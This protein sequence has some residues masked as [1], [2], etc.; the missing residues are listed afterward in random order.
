MARISHKKH[1]ELIK[2]DDGD[3]E[4]TVYARSNGRDTY[5]VTTK[6]HRS[7]ASHVEM[8]REDAQRH[9]LKP[10]RTCVEAVNDS[11]DGYPTDSRL[12]DTIRAAAAEAEAN[13]DDPTSAA[14]RAAHE[15][16]RSE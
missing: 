6:C 1:R 15:H 16:D 3:P 8:T 13:G 4:T 9:A 10:C 2:A 14:L 12:A 5:H 7:P 11:S